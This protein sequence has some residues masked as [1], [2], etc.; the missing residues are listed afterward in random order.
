MVSIVLTGFLRHARYLERLLNTHVTGVHALAYDE[1]SRISLLRAAGSALI[2]DASVTFGG[3]EPKALIRAICETRG[4]PVIH[5]WAGSDVLTIA[6][7]PMHVEAVRLLNISHWACAENLVPELA[8]L[9][10]SARYVPLASAAVPSEIAAMPSEFRVLTYLPEPRRDF[11]GQ[12]A[13]WKAAQALPN[14]RFIAVGAGRPQP[15]A[16]PNVEYTG[17]VHDMEARLDAASVLIRFTEH[18]GLSLGVIEALSRGRH[19][20]WTH[21]LPGVTMVRSPD[22]VITELQRFLALHERGVLDINRA[23]VEYA[24]AFHEP[25]RIAQNVFANIVGAIEAAGADSGKQRPMRLAI[26][27]SPNFSARVAANAHKYGE[28]VVPTV[29]R[30]QSKSDA[31]VS[32]AALLRSHVWYSIGPPALPQPFEVAARACR[33]RSVIHWLGNDVDSLA[34]TPGM[35]RKYRSTRFLHLAQDASV[36]Q[37]LRGLGLRASVTCVPA[38][39]RVESIHP[40]PDRF[41]LLLYVPAE[42]SELYGRHQYERLMRALRGADIHY[43]IVGGGTIN[44]PEGVSAEL[45][46]W[47]HDLGDIYDRSTALARFTQTDSFSAMIVEALLHGRYVLWSND[48]PYA[49]RLRNFHDLEDTV[50]SLL[51]LHERGTLA[52][53]L[54]AALAMSEL[55]SPE[56]CFQKLRG[57][58]RTS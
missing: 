28:H 43:I 37:R 14:V 48:F 58:L 18:D 3:H 44:V 34:A 26:S 41:T 1:C 30:T 10:I 13:I 21:D 55:Y 52:P 33:K 2:A 29:L 45:L 51:A 8:A 46:G 31:A 9:G 24:A 42:H 56:D 6:R 19:V 36:A 11:Y 17:E 53:R 35:I 22:G 39:A 16:P 4:R 40:F 57:C 50:R 7:S 12:R 38:L 32:L 49:A 25:R 47:R 23:G 27:G 15:E 20:L 54:D 5:I